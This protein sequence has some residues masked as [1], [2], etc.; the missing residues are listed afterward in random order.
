VKR[1]RHRVL[2]SRAYAAVRRFV[3]GVTRPFRRARIIVIYRKDLEGPLTEYRARVPI[4]V[5]PAPEEI[6]PRLADLKQLDED[7]G[8]LY[9][10]RA[11]RGQHCFVAWVDDEPVGFNWLAY[12]DEVDEDRKVRMAEDEVYCLDAFT[13]PDWRGHAIHTELLSRMLE[14]AKAA[15]YRTAYTQVS[16]TH[17]RSSKTHERLDWVVSGRLLH[18]R[19]PFGRR[20]YMRRLSGSQRPIVEMHR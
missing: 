3:A 5:E 20:A 1:L 17:R 9:V 14:H 18:V 11:R 7:L 15:G 16:S 10:R 8:A 2:R 13:V 19:M 12:D 4:R 6:L